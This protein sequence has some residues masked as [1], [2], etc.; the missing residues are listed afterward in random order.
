MEG[1][2][3]EK[4]KFE[5][6]WKYIMQKEN[7]LKGMLMI[8][9]SAFCFACMNVCVRLAGD[10]PSVQK[11]FFRNLVAAVFAAS[12]LC[13]NHICPRVKKEYWGPLAVRCIF[14]T[15]G[16]LC[17]FYAVDHLL[18]ADAS[19][20]NKLSP[21]FAI[22]FSFLLLKEK[23][24]PTQAFCVL[25]AFAGCLF[26]VKPGFQ[27]AALIPALIGVC[28]GLGAGIAYTMV[29][30][31]GTHGVKGPVIVFY[32]SAF[33]CVAVLPWIVVNYAP[34]TMEQVGTLLLAGLFA[35]GGQFSITAAYTFAPARKISIF[36]YSQIIFATVLGF[37]L[38][39]EV[40]DAYS[41]VGYGLII[42]ASFC[43]F[44]Y[45]RREQA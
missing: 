23:I 35:A 19:I 1:S 36:D 11:S 21:F 6:D 13:K 33:S 34:M 12:I 10:I 44:V 43:M 16:I 4:N 31:L 14:G 25:L 3:N 45:N 38:F 27:N 5:K 39:G 37:L 18:V 22:V 24:K 28:G 30:V 40:P 42:L 15:V 41:F 20:L 8:I 29:R 9:L 32:F 7:Y 17:N 26:V 2:Y